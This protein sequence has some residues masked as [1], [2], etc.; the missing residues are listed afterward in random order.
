MTCPSTLPVHYLCGQAGFEAFSGGAKRS[1]ET[2]ASS[3]VCKEKIKLLKGER[4]EILRESTPSNVKKMGNVRKLRNR[5]EVLVTVVVVEIIVVIVIV[6][7]STVVV[8]VIT[9]SCFFNTILVS[10]VKSLLKN[11][12]LKPKMP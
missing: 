8:V 3:C 2:L 5:C 10:S 11:I 12:S 9:V 1:L 6:V 7:K 4:D